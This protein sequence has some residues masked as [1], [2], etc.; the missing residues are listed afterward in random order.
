MKNPDDRLAA[1]RRGSFVA[2]RRREHDRARQAL[3]WQVAQKT[4]RHP[5]LGSS[6]EAHKI[7]ANTYTIAGMP[8]TRIRRPLHVVGKPP[9]PDLIPPGDLG[10]G[11]HQL[12]RSRARPES[13]YASEW[14]H[15]C[16]RGSRHARSA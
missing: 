11:G 2:R 7:A 16:A 12:G 4:K 3:R 8:S 15:I 10:G 13:S 9:K 1:H 14:R 6:G 5:K